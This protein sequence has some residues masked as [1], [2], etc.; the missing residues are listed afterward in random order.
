MTLESEARCC[1]LTTKGVLPRVQ[2]PAAV[3]G[4]KYR[5]VSDW[6]AFRR[7]PG[8]PINTTRPPLFPPQV[9]NFCMREHTPLGPQ[10]D[11]PVGLSNHVQVMLDDDHCVP[12]FDQAV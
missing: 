5:L 8:A 4:Y 9:V 11:N 2:G 1:H 3:P 10:V 12:G 7:S 6:G